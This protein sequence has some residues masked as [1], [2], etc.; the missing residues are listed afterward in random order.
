MKSTSTPCK[1]TLGQMKPW[2]KSF[3][4]WVL[5]SFNLV[6]AYDMMSLILVQCSIEDLL[7][8]FLSHYG[9]RLGKSLGKTSKKFWKTSILASV[10]VVW[11]VTITIAKNAWQ[12]FLTL[13]IACNTDA[14]RGRDLDLILLN[15]NLSPSHIRKIWLWD[16]TL[17]TLDCY[18]FTVWLGFRSL[19]FCLF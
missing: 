16:P 14:M 12:P 17:Q 3:C 7:K 1:E 15:I 18:V 13:L 2:F 10:D 9:G 8:I 5:S 6:G 11:L 19:K 4:N